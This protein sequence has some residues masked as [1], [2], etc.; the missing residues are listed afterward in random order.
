MCTET[1]KLKFSKTREIEL[2]LGVFLNELPI[3]YKYPKQRF[4]VCKADE[5]ETSLGDIRAMHTFF[6]EEE[7]RESI[8][9]LKE[10]E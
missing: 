7:M 3:T 2:E 8:T 6:T 9:K 10:K 4:S 1:Q 5:K